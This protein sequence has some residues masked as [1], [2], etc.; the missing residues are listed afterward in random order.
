M[1]PIADGILAPNRSATSQGRAGITGRLLLLLFLVN[2]AFTGLL[3]IAHDKASED[4]LVYY[5]SAVNLFEGEGFSR[6]F[7][8][9]P[10]TPG[11]T[12]PFE[13]QGRVLF[14]FLASLAFRIFG[15]S[16]ATSNLVA[17][18]FKSCLVVPIVLIGKDLF[19][20]DAMGLVAGVMYTVNPAY[21]SLGILTMPETTTAFF[22]YL[23]ILFIVAYYKKSRPFL[24][25]L[26][27]LAAS[28]SYLARPEGLFL[29]I[30]GIATVL[31]GRRRW[32]DALFFLLFPALTL[33]LG[34]WL[35]FGRIASI[36]P[37]QTSLVLLPDW[38]DF[39]V[40]ERFTPAAYLDRVGG[41]SGALAVRIYNCLLFLKNSFADGLWL[42]RRV[43]LL[44]FTFIIPIFAS[45]F[46]AAPRRDRA[47]LYVLSLFVAAQMLFTIGYPGYP[48]MSADF[49]HGQTVGPFVLIL[50]SAGLVHLWRGCRQIKVK[51]AI[52]TVCRMVGYLLAAHYTLFAIVFLSLIL[53][54]ALW[55]PTVRTALV[56]GATW[57]RDNLPGDAVIMT[58]KPAVVHYFSQRPAIIIPTAPYADIMAYAQGHG[59]TPVSY[60]HLTLP[61]IYSV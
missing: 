14:P 6:D 30:L 44:P 16:L 5:A 23:A 11:V 59:V 33:T 56:Q 43:G 4:A 26:A 29:L 19:Q 13:S 18:F 17:A 36:S 47:Y 7:K 57:I 10:A 58:R 9:D 25:V 48:R 40:L 38:T 50:A 45:L 21:M 28:L 2:L 37:Y 61:T 35:I 24:M 51:P 54:E 8:V 3:S 41:I 49:R 32:E 55:T 46:R 12:P 22:Y 39:Y 15:V 1:S 27:G 52:Q 31:M 42:D 20:D 53:N 60:T 34:N